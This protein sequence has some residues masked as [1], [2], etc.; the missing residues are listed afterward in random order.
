MPTSLTIGELFTPAP[1]GVGSNPTLPPATGTW[2]GLLYQIAGAVG[3]PTT[4]FQPGAPER[5]IL[6]IVSVAL[7]QDDALISIYAQGG[8]LVFASTGTVSYVAANGQTVTKFVTP[9]PSIP[10]QN[11]TGAPG[12]L[13]ALCQSM[14][15][16]ERLQASFA[17]GPLA[18][19]NTTPGTIGPFAPGTYHVANTLTRATY[20]NAASL[21]VPTG[22]ISG[23]GGL[24]SGVTPG[25]AITTVTTQAAHGLSAGSVVFINGVNGVSGINGAFA[26]I[27]SVPS[28]TSFQITLPTSGTWTSGGAVTSCTV[29]NF[30]ADVIGA[31]SN[32]APG[33]VTTTVSVTVGV[34]VANLV[35]WS[36]ANYESNP[37]YA[38]RS[39]LKLG[40]ISPNGPSQAYSYFALT[41]SQILADET[42]PI[43]MTNGPIA[44]AI[45]TSNPQ[46]GLTTVT[47]ASSSPQSSALNGAVTPGCSQLPLTGATN[48]TPIVISTVTSHG[49]SNGNT[50]EVSGVLGNTAANGTW[51]IAGVTSSTFQL[52]GSTGNGTYVAATGSVEGGD[53]GQ[54]DVLV[55]KNCTPN[56]IIALTQSALAFPISVVATVIV[57]ASLIATYTAAALASLQAYVATLPIGGLILPP[58]ITGILPISGIEGAL[59]DAGVVTAGSPTYVLDIPSLTINGGL[60]DLTF[61]TFQHYA[62]LLAPTLNV[63]GV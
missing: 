18:I 47:V 34:G 20:A 19:A 30:L 57:P 39:Q 2:L 24:I 46:T 33:A 12:W 13:D 28:S 29:A 17:S 7:A 60:V 22:V 3:L 59:E 50:V 38:N 55:Q 56:G 1:S 15:D 54:V 43:V 40:T 9:D 42:P 35:A 36:A 32:A 51:S 23:T 53:L 5:S 31:A 11:P 14:F 44:S 41:A 63:V 4:S 16:A 45:T 52:V 21:T 26:A 10:S 37:A 48:A 49:L 6:A 27:S 58:A 8:F 61:P 25:A 62:I